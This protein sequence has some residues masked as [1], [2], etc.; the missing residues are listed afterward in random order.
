[1]QSLLVLDELDDTV[2]Q[3]RPVP[4]SRAR[5]MDREP[6]VRA[7]DRID[8]ALVQELGTR[9]TERPGGPQLRD[10]VRQ[11]REHV[12]TAK[13]LPLTRFVR[14]DPQLVYDA[15]DRT[16]AVYPIVLQ[17]VRRRG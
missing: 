2:H 12:E 10:A 6:L 8:A 16:R 11:L 5:R 9:W 3:A 15:L 7:L 13:E 1:M 17:D 4:L 14:I